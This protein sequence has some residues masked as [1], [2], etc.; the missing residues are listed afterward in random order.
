MTDSEEYGRGKR[1]KKP[2]A[3]Q[4]VSQ[5]LLSNKGKQKATRAQKLREKNEKKK[6]NA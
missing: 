1:I 5:E 6:S 3:V 4:Q 2:S